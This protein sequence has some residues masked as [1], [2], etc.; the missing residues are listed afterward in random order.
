MKHYIYC[1][2]PMW[3]VRG[4]VV[5]YL[6]HLY[7]G[8]VLNGGFIGAKNL[9][10]NFLFPSSPANN[11]INENLGNEKIYAKAMK[12][13]KDAPCAFI[14]QKK[15]WF[16]EIM[17]EEQ[18]L[19]I[20]LSRIKSIHIHGAYNF[21]PVYNFLRLYGIEKDVIKILTTHNP[22]KPEMEDLAYSAGRIKSDELDDFHFFHNFRDELAFSLSDALFFPCEEAMEAYYKTWPE[23]SSITKNKPIYFSETGALKSDVITPA[24][25]LR[26]S[27]KIPEDATVFLYI[28]RFMTVRGIDIYVEAAK[29]ILEQNNKVYFLAVGDEMPVPFI[30]HTHWLQLPFTNYPADYVA[31]ANACVIASR[32]NYFDLSMIEILSQGTPL[33]AAETGGCRYLGGKTRGVVYF[34]PDSVDDLVSVMLDFCRINKNEIETMRYDNL[35]LYNKELTAERFASRYMEI[36][37]IIYNDFNVSPSRREVTNKLSPIRHATDIEGRRLVPESENKPKNLDLAPKER[38]LRKLRKLRNSPWA[39]FRDGFKNIFRT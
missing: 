7:S 27:C 37:D 22:T 23:F 14:D 38:R 36:I 24:K 12:Y 18:A 6:S 29:K 31:M 26:R 32:H 34:Q 20:D 8:M 19:K 15:K 21:L 9:Q 3:H 33:I 1:H 13:K 28:G 5:G 2:Q 16:K 30:E 39:Y 35:N 17:P 10:H 11:Q 4:G 25:V